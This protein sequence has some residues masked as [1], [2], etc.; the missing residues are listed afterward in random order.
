MYLGLF[1][2]ATPVSTQV[3]KCYML[4]V[5]VVIIN[6]LII[7]SAKMLK[8]EWLAEASKFVWTASSS[9]AK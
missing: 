2:F 4:I 9:A 6:W 7:S 8:I 5:I 1:F 3:Y